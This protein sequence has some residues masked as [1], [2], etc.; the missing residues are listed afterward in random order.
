MKIKSIS[1]Q[2]TFAIAPFLNEKIGIEIEVSGD[3]YGTDSEGAIKLAKKTVER[4]HKEMNPQ[5][6]NGQNPLPNGDVPVTQVEKG[7]PDAKI[8]ADIFACTRLD[9]PT[10][11]FSYETYVNSQKNKPDLKAAY[12]LMFK[13]LSK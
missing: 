9:G 10:G 13:K 8:V 3:P 4:W 6:F 1:Y 2:K 5:L 12:D 11:L 7:N